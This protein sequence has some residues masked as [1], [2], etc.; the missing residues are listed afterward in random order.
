MSGVV[1]GRPGGWV[2]ML[3]QQFRWEE[4]APVRWWRLE[5]RTFERI[6][7]AYR[8]IQKKKCMVCSIFS[9]CFCLW[10][11]FC[12]FS[13]FVPFRVIHVMSKV[14]IYFD[15]FCCIREFRA[16]VQSIG[17]RNI[18]PWNRLEWERFKEKTEYCGRK[19]RAIHHIQ[20]LSIQLFCARIRFTMLVHNH[21]IL[22]CETFNCVLKRGYRWWKDGQWISNDV[23]KLKYLSVFFTYL[24]PLSFTFKMILN[25][26]HR[27][28]WKYP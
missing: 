17:K 13:F 25:R 2:G 15:A 14:I 27:H 28:R 24:F 3:V 8:A 10:Q 26:R 22:S 1:Y 21:K 20:A 11:F 6:Y 16:L 5:S 4:K 18:C 19:T 23:C 7:V 9:S 12:L